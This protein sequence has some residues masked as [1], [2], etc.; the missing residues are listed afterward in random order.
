MEQ[1]NCSKF[2]CPEKR[3]TSKKAIQSNGIAAKT[4]KVNFQQ[5]KVNPQYSDMEINDHENRIFLKANTYYKD[6]ASEIYP[7]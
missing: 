7:N 3:E 1:K 2:F 6:L 5:N 4:A